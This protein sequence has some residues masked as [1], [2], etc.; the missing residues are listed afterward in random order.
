MVA[1]D[2]CPDDSFKNNQRK[3]ACA[4][5]AYEHQADDAAQEVAL[6]DSIVRWLE[7]DVRAHVM[8]LEHADTYPHE[9][10]EQMKEL[11]LFGA[12]IAAE[13]GGLGLKAGT[14]ARIIEKISETWMSLAGIFNSHLIMAACVQRQGTP[15]Q[16]TYYL[17]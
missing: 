12:T 16:K 8:E 15:A 4:M 1:A 13:Y 7:R 10:V 14:Y 5:A 2:T 11:G 17:P 6:L 3:R 9:M